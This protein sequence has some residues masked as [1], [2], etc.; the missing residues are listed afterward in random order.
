VTLSRTRSGWYL[1]NVKRDKVYPRS[2]QRF[3]V[4][5]T[6]RA[7]ENLVRRT[8]KAFGREPQSDRQSIAA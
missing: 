8:L 6:D 3:L 1:N 2:A 5:I 4:T 7:A